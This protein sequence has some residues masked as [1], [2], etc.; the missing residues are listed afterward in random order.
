MAIFI[1][2]PFIQSFTNVSEVTVEHNFGRRVI[3]SVFVTED[4]TGAVNEEIICDIEEDETDPLNVI[5][6]RFTENLSGEVRIG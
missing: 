2:E 6:V 3:P 5:I 1:Y 4:S